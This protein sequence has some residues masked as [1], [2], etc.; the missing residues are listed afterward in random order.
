MPETVGFQTLIENLAAAKDAAGLD[1]R[2]TDGAL[3]ALRSEFEANPNPFDRHRAIS[4]QI[5][6]TDHVG[7]RQLLRR[8][9]DE[10]DAETLKA[11]IA[12][13]RQVFERSPDEGW[14]AWL[15]ALAESVSR[16][17]NRHAARLS[18]HE[19]SFAPTH[20]STVIQLRQACRC[21]NQGRW[22]E[23]YEEVAFLSKQGFLPI[24]SRA[25]LIT[26]RGLIELWRLTKPLRAR[27]SLEEA[28]TMAADDGV[29]VASVG[30][31][32]LAEGNVDKAV[33]Y[34]QRAMQFAPQESNG[35]VGMGSVCEQEGRLDEAETWYRQ[36]ISLDG[37]DSVGY[38]RLLRLLGGPAK[39]AKHQDEFV[40]LIERRIAVDEDGEYDAYVSAG[41]IYL[42]NK[43]FAEARNW[44]QKAIQLEKDRPRGYSALG[45]LCRAE[46]DD[47]GTEAFCWKSINAA[48]ESPD[49]YIVLARFYEEKRR[50]QDA[51]DLYSRFPARPLEWVSF[52]RASIGRMHVELERADEAEQILFAELYRCPDE[53]FALRALEGLADR[54]FD[55]QGDAAAARRVYDRILVSLGEQYRGTHQ[56]MLA[57]LANKEGNSDFERTAYAEAVEHYRTAM[58]LDSSEDVYCTNLARALLRLQEPGKRVQAL[59]EAIE[60]YERAQEIT[61]GQEHDERIRRL[62]RRRDLAR[63]HGEK[64]LDRISVV[65][66]IAVEGTSE[67]TLSEGLSLSVVA[68]RKRLRQELGVKIPGVRF[69]G[70]E[71]D[72]SDGTYVVMINEIPVVTGHLSLKQRFFPGT[73]EVLSQLGVTGEPASDPV[74]G[75]DGVW[76][77][78]KDW[79]KVESQE[80]E[81]WPVTQY[82]VRHLEAVLR[83]NVGEFVGHQEIVN[84]LERELASPFT[85]I[86]AS[87][88]MVTALTTVCRALLAEEVPIQ[89]FRDVCAAFNDSY[90][91]RVSPRA[92]VEEVRSLPAFR[93]R[94]PGNDPQRSLLRLSGGFEAEIRHSLYGR[95]GQQ[96]LAM[97]P[98]HCQEALSAVR[99]AVGERAQTL[100]V[101]DAALR[102]FVRKLVELE[103]PNLPV[104]SRAELRSDL[105]LARASVIEPTDG[106]S[107][108]QVEFA[109]SALVEPIEVAPQGGV[110]RGAAVSSDARIEV[111]VGEDFEGAVSAADDKPIAEMFSIMQESLFYELGLVL[112][113]VQLRTD[114]A[115]KSGEFRIRLG[116]VDHEPLTGLGHHEFLVNDTVERL[117]LLD[118]VG[119]GAVNPATG[120]GCALLPLTPRGVETCLQAGLTTWGPHGFVVLS[121]AAAI[122]RNAA[123]FQTDDVTQY[124]L[125]SLGEAFP[126]LVRIALERYGAPGISMLFRELLEEQISIRDLRTI[127]ESLLSVNGTTDV[128]LNRFIVFMAYTDGYCPSSTKKNAGELTTTELADFVRVWLKRYISYK[129]KRGG[130]TLVVYLVDPDIEERM[131]QVS[132]RPLSGAEREKLRAAIREEVDSLPSTAANPVVLTSMEIRRALRKTIEHDFPRLPVVS[133]QE[134]SPDMNI[135]PIARIAW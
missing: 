40:S 20:Q 62:R 86:R 15:T 123:V 70:N 79:P 76:I 120:A 9:R 2:V 122:R 22:E 49:G 75:V 33:K 126:D 100:V 8:F 90:A 135:Q 73:G 114:R 85:E 4:A 119:R 31:Y 84:L 130:N 25:R 28:K 43:R 55:E 1:A 115:L 44:Y 132:A 88:H 121:L 104:L 52:A 50:W 133:Y 74:S 108:E 81:L 36:A 69:R 17:R 87:S 91:K 107:V 94:L 127:L 116:G 5:G 64:V 34:F 78:E 6:A 99:N 53:T 134:L 129:Y 83:R 24:H 46:G 105:D 110:G 39:L 82:L 93:D 14:K 128:D 21:M 54:Y 32:W 67:E 101:E 124:N 37:G 63:G 11:S 103:F 92:I 42:A 47:A 57:R 97:E 12:D 80:P 19:F 26:L 30:D 98:S 13:I 68:M 125:D 117:S 7:W 106:P 16:S 35:Y 71:T 48:P 3:R 95:D 77:D 41:D 51:L 45:Q 23:A 38:E 66:P 27:A 102:P 65:T 60:C 111:F 113:Q 109:R 58:K 18:A 29:V 89:P 59:E 10:L 131:A 56:K 118:I 112:P 61:T 96:V 72:F